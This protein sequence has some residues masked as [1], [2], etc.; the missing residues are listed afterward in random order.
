MTEIAYEWGIAQLEVAPSEDGLTDVVKTI[1]W[2]L[3]ATDGELSA[4]SYGSV[5]MDAPEAEAFTPYAELSKDAVIGWLEAK[6][7]ADAIRAG[8]AGQIDAQR[9]PQII[10]PSLPW[11]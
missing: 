11:A 2:T 8:L 7:D 9:A 5:G 3:S 6:L 1:H 4:S 10:T